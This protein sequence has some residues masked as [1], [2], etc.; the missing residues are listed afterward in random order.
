MVNPNGQKLGLRRT[1]DSLV[2]IAKK[3]RLQD[4][5]PLSIDVWLDG[6]EASGEPSFRGTKFETT[7]SNRPNALQFKTNE[8]VD[9]CSISISLR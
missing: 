1:R 4:A 2:E 9:S 6:K 5:L 8:V 7:N 3:C